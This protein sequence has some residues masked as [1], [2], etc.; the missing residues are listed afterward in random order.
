MTAKANF[1]GICQA[2]AFKKDVSSG[3]LF[4]KP[5]IKLA[6]KAFAAF[7]HDEMV[8]KLD[9]AQQKEIL[10]L[11]GAHLW[12]PSGAGRPMKEWTCLPIAHGRLWPDLAEKALVHARKLAAKK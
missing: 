9:G 1:D 5:C 11:K 12:D 4:G 3:N 6:T 8:F 10:S 2:L 7:Q